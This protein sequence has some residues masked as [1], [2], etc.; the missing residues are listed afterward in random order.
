MASNKPACTCY[1]YF[2]T[3]PVHSNNLGFIFGDAAPSLARLK[4]I[5]RL[6]W[7]LWQGGTC[8]TYAA[9][10]SGL[11]GTKSASLWKR[12]VRQTGAPLP[13]QPRKPINVLEAPVCFSASR[14]SRNTL[15][16][17]WFGPVAG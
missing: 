15:W 10:Y 12:G 8:L 13:Q 7:L 14:P 17:R 2:L 3:V 5:Y 16:L 4:H 1:E 9:F 11:P 6:S